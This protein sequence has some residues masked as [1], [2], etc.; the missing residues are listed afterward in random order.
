MT[1]Y[2]VTSA[3]PYANGPLHF[4]HLAGVYIPADIYTRHKKLS[5]ERAIHICGS[6]EHGVAIMLNA[7]KAKVPYKEYVDG[8]HKEH[9]ALFDAFNIHFEYFGQTSSDYHAEEVLPWFKS[10][11]EKGMIEPRDGQQLQCGDCHNHLPDRFVGGECYECHYPSARG[12]ECPNCGIII[13]SVKL[14]NPVC[15]I[16]ES[17]NIKEVTVTQYYLT[18]SK[19]HE[20]YREWLTKKIPEFRK[21]VGKYVDSLTKENLHDRAISR[22][23]DWGID[24]PLAEAKGKKLYVWF[25]APIGYVSNT[26]QWLKETGSSEDYKKDWWTN[27]DTKIEHFIGK[28]NIIFHCIIFPV[29][30]M[31]SEQVNVCTDV[32][33]NQYL[34]LEGKQFS[35]SAGWYVDA[36]EAVEK[37]GSDA[38][39]YYLTAISPEASDSSFTW[40]G[41]QARL[42]G[43]LANNIGNL[44]NRCL[45]FW[46]KNWAEG[47]SEEA[48]K[49]YQQVDKVSELSQKL[50]L[51]RDCLDEKAIKIALE[52]SMQMGH[53]TNEYFSERAPW[54][55]FKMDPKI[56]ELTIAETGAMILIV[57]AA[58]NPFLPDLSQNI[59]SLFGN[60]S[61]ES[62]AKIY[63]GDFSA[64]D[65][66]FKAAGGTPVKAPKALVPKIEDDVIAALKEELGKL[67]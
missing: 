39:R 46:K 45:K 37:F 33:A 49:S 54:A 35:K 2:L 62:I 52:I 59:F 44:V 40:E 4:G 22:D 36:K 8:W 38:L 60:V 27:S 5:G 42:N 58:L 65:Q 10:L 50:A 19:A 18:L 53:M 57:A 56:A 31:M 48:L 41:F 64:I 32:P 23:L 28:D 14:I 12:D 51:V 1:K 20:K 11:H 7:Q 66:I 61:D 47:M 21:T 29:M 13:D 55:S 26:K 16:C 25:D 6:D 43:E 15:Q 63:Q 17:T 34:N 9:K 30:S 3:L 67:N 24:V